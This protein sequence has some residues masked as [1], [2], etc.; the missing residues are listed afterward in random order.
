MFRRTAARAATLVVAASIALAA[1]SGSEGSE[2]SG[3]GTTEYT[4]GVLEVAQAQLL[5]DVVA[6]FE[7]SVKSE[8]GGDATV[9]FDVQ[10]ANGD[11]SLI[12]SLTRDFAGSDADAFAV[13]GTPAVIAMAAQ[14]KDR[15]IFALAM[16][17]PVG[18]GLAESLE[19]P[20]GNVTGSIDYVDPD[21]L[22]DDIVAIHPDA[23]TVGTLYDPSNQNMQVWIKDLKTAIEAHGLSLKEATIASSAEVSQAAR[24]L[25]DGADVILVGPDALVTAGIDAVGASAAGAKLPLYVVG[26]DVTVPGVLGSLGPN[27]PELGTSAGV[28]AAKVLQGA[29]P[30]TIAFS[31]P[32]EIQ[33]ALNSEYAAQLGVT[34]P[35]SLAGLVVEQ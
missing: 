21:Q 16:G 25:S 11:Q 17:D 22:V 12:T 15:P 20:G 30:G 10:N 7:E 8:L 29:D 24:S 31:V 9:T 1:C 23:S 26:G 34:V 28:G 33:I 14:V 27:Y 32:G 18:A 6:A 5:D 35:D 4:I 3:S 2:S 19:A 13:I